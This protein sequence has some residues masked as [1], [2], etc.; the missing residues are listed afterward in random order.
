MA[1]NKMQRSLDVVNPKTI[2]ALTPTANTNNASQK[3]A[4]STTSSKSGTASTA[5]SVGNQQPYSYELYTVGQ[6]LT[7]QQAYTV[8]DPLQYQNYTAGAP[9]QLSE[10]QF[11]P[12]AE[13]EVNE[14]GLDANSQNIY[15]TYQGILGDN[16]YEQYLN[17]ARD[18]TLNATN[19]AYNDNARN[20]YQMYRSNQSKLPEQLSRLGVTGGGSETASL[21]LLNNY[22][23][24][25][26]GNESQRAQQLSNLNAQYDQLRADYAKDLANQLASAYLG[27]AQNVQGENWNRQNYN[28]QGLNEANRYNTGIRNEQATTNWNRNNTVNDNNV[29]LAN[30]AIESMWS[31]T[32]DVNDKN[33]E[34]LNQYGYYNWQR[35]NEVADQNVGLANQYGQLNTQYNINERDT[36]RDRGWTTEDADKAY[37]RQQETARQEQIYGLAQYMLESGG[38]ASMLKSVLGLSDSEAK[39][40][41]KAWKKAQ[42]SNSSSGGSSGRRSG[43][44]YRYSGGGST[45]GIDMSGYGNSDSSGSEKSSGNKEKT[46]SSNNN[47]KGKTNTEKKW[48]ANYRTYR[49]KVL[50][51]A[52][53]NNPAAKSQVNVMLSSLVAGAQVSNAQLK[54][55]WA[56]Y[57]R[58]GGGNAQ[59]KQPT[60]NGKTRNSGTVGKT[61]KLKESE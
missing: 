10:Y 51:L 8:G 34:L 23:G 29:D 7:P 55:L 21:G 11:N 3:T 20:Y 14:R 16:G 48:D 22:S 17:S 28:N 26:Y 5:T 60:S 52:K 12:L 35:G 4:S 38:D 27:M 6:Q 19:K 53:N 58:Y 56:L 41:V 24:N 45:S 50:A 59:K 46:S 37:Q 32:N 54:S 1:N 42:S 30:R 31:R 15:N 25:L 61:V 43:S 13:L 2:M 49:N 9:L 57:N 33:A 18:N 40:L 47:T 39:N 44:Y 36:L